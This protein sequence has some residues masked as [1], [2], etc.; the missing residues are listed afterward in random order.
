MLVWKTHI[1]VSHGHLGDLRLHW[2]LPNVLQ[3]MLPVFL[4]PNAMIG[5]SRLP[6]LALPIQLALGPERETT[7]DKLNRPL[8][9]FPRTEDQMQVIGHHHEGVKH[10]GRFSVML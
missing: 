9:R 6:N 1:G 4:I 2:I 3:M 5:E 8:N 7:L 10:I